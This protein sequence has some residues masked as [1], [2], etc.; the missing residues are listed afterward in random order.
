LDG[1]S[2]ISKKKKEKKQREISQQLKMREQL[3][4]GCS[5]VKEE[6]GAK[7]AEA[8]LTFRLHFA[9]INTY[10]KKIYSSIHSRARKGK[11]EQKG[12]EIPWSSFLG[13]GSDARVL[14]LWG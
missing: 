10:Y 3:Q 6:A 4:N 2:Q 1:G 13:F 7:S 12:S 8:L 9:L 14:G 5:F 11:R